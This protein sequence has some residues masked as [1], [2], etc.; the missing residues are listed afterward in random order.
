MLSLRSSSDASG[1]PECVV[2]QALFD[3]LNSSLEL[4][5][6][7]SRPAKRVEIWI[8]A[9]R[10]AI[11]ND[12]S[13]RESAPR[14]VYNEVQPKPITKNMAIGCKIFWRKGGSSDFFFPLTIR[15]DTERLRLT[16]S[17]HRTAPERRPLN[18]RQVF[19]RLAKDAPDIERRT[20]TVSQDDFEDYLSKADY[21]K[22]HPSYVQKF[23]DRWRGKALEHFITFSLIK[24]NPNGVY[25][26]VAADVSPSS[27][28][29]SRVY[30]VRRAMMQDLN[31]PAGVHGD[32]IGSNAA[33][34]PLDDESVNGV[35]S[36][37]SWEHFEGVSDILFLAEAARLLRPGGKLCITPLLFSEEVQVVTSPKYWR[38]KYRN[39]QDFPNFDPRAE[40]V[41][42]D[43]IKQRQIK[44]Y[45]VKALRDD[46]KLISSLVPR[47]V[48]INPV[49]DDMPA[50]GFALMMLNPRED[51]Q[52]AD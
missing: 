37:N 52:N 46:L 47:I 15:D 14:V 44:S 4:R 29:L 38:T 39:A 9:R 25:L 35:I 23:G 41:I 5:A 10:I 19:E 1:A 32:K 40:V 16:L 28:I 34:I 48:Q 30:G 42:D 31:Y 27:E 36:H 6:R 13:L 12:Q 7:L 33:D 43:A 2:E 21:L 3:V 18:R 17:R 24:P 45:S 26:D 22:H 20:H 51:Q 49:G 11:I 50:P 8:E